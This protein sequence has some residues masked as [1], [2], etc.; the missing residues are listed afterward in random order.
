MCK[1]T[2]IRCAICGK[3]IAYAE[4]CNPEP[5]AGEGCCHECDKQFVIPIRMKRGANGLNPYEF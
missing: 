3:E 5:F 1:E 2:K 4:S